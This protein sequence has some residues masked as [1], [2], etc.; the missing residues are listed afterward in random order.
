MD[1]ACIAMNEALVKHCNEETHLTNR[2]TQ[3]AEG[4]NQSPSEKDRS[5]FD[6]SLNNQMKNGAYQTADSTNISNV[7]VA[8]PFVSVAAAFRVIIT[9][10]A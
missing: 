8:A 4:Q 7:I 2:N 5:G 6:A 10:D 9:I 1:L 3:I